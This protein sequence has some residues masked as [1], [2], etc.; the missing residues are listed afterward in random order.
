VGGGLYTTQK[1]WYKNI[2]GEI[3]TL[4]IL[5]I[6][7]LKGGRGCGGEYLLKPPSPIKIITAGITSYIFCILFHHVFYY[8]KI[9]V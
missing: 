6:F 3:Y 1:G 9:S 5:Q 2:H 8:G 7:S 4:I